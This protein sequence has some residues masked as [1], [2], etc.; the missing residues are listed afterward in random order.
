MCS[1]IRQRISREIP[2]SS[3]AVHQERRSYHGLGIC[4]DSLSELV[5]LHLKNGSCSILVD[6]NGF[7]LRFMIW[8]HKPKVHNLGSSKPDLF[9]SVDSN[10]EAKPKTHIFA[11]LDW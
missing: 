8:D 11:H 5:S 9:F 1:L 2:I 10:Q 3:M 7:S 6:Y 4:F